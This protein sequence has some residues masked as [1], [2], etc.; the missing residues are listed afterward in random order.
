MDAQAERRVKWDGGAVDVSSLPVLD[1]P[2]LTEDLDE[3]KANID[4]FGIALVANAL[5]P[6]EVAV[7]DERLTEQAAGE[8]KL[9]LGSALRGDEAFGA[10]PTEPERVR[11]RLWNL[12]NKGECGLPR[13]DRTFVQHLL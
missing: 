9:G 11:R 1:Y 13:I 8:A 2:A 3:A 5:S 6:E 7:L 4:E 10:R 12:G